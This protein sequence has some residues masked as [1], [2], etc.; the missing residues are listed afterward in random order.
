MPVKPRQYKSDK[1]DLE[2]LIA[3]GEGKGPGGFHGQTVNGTVHSTGP[4]WNNNGC[5]GWLAGG[6]YEHEAEGP[7][8][9]AR[10]NR[11]GE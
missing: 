3:K 11:T 5:G 10:T 8:A 4:G 7:W 2:K 6:C 9:G 1:L